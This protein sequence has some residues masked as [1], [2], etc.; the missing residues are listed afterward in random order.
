M[1]SRFFIHRADLRHGHLDRDRDHGAFAQRGLPVSKFPDITP[2]P[3]Q[4]PAFY[5]GSNAQVVAET[6][7]APIEQG[8]NGVEDMLYMS[9]SSADDGSYLR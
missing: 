6:V 7:A 9:S 5:P 8:V 2:P 3:V 4:V 1:L